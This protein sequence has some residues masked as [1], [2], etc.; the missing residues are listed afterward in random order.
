VVPEMAEP[1]FGGPMTLQMF[2]AQ[3]QHRETGTKH[4]AKP[5]DPPTLPCRGD[6]RILAEDLVRIRRPDEWERY[7][8][9]QRQARIDPNIH[10]R[11]QTRITMRD[12]SR[13]VQN[14][15]RDPRTKRKDC[16]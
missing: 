4:G 13:P 10:W 12:T 11:P 14:L 1:G 16:E 9:H 7:A 3:D 2:V 5:V 6:Q 8:V 15:A